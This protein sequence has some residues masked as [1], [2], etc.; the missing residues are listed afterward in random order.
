[1]PNLK[2]YVNLKLFILNTIKAYKELFRMN[3]EGEK[4]AIKT[5]KQRLKQIELTEDAIVKE[6]EAIKEIQKQIKGETKETKKSI[7][8]ID[9]KIQGLKDQGNSHEKIIKILE[10]EKKKHRLLKPEVKEKLV[11]DIADIVEHRRDASDH[12]KLL[13]AFYELLP[14]AKIKSLISG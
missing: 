3:A 8:M 4:E 6:G 11:N 5:A 14:G 10:N 9:Q 7:K 2:I 1:M 12:M 13:I